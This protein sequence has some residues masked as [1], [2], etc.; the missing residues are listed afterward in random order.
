METEEI[1]ELAKKLNADKSWVVFSGMT[2]EMKE[3]IEKAYETIQGMD[4]VDG[5]NEAYYKY[6]YTS[7]EKCLI[8]GINNVRTAIIAGLSIIL[9]GNQSRGLECIAEVLIMIGNMWRK[10][11]INLD[12]IEDNQYDD[13]WYELK[14]H[15]EYKGK[16][17]I[18]KG[19][20][21]S[22]DGTKEIDYYLI[23]DATKFCNEIYCK[24]CKKTRV[25]I[26][27]SIYQIAC[28]K[29]GYGLTP[30]FFTEEE[31]IYWLKEGE[32]LDVEKSNNEELKKKHEKILSMFKE[33]VSKRIEIK[34]GNTTI[35]IHPEEF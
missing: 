22:P 30:D 9:K 15:V 7:S 11:K 5:Y 18:Q 1:E 8:H 29:C 16:S 6:G 34:K 35:I 3:L 31:L 17:Y 2:K 20:L 25:P 4:R 26:L 28:S 23:R 32:E 12:K 10:L 14:T 24:Y 33:K 21:Y 27:V 19:G 13:H